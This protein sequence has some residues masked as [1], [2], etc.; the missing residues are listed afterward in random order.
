MR[1][2]NDDGEAKEIK[3]PEE[4]ETAL[5]SARRP[6][7]LVV[8]VAGAMSSE[9]P[10]GMPVECTN[11]NDA[12]VVELVRL[13]GG[14]YKTPT[15]P[16][17]PYIWHDTGEG[18]GWYSYESQHYPCPSC[19]RVRMIDLRQDDSGLGPKE[20]MLTVAMDY[21]PLEGKEEARKTAL[22]VLQRTP[23]PWGWVT[24]WGDYG[25]GKT[26]AL[27]CLVADFVRAGVPSK[28]IVASQMLGELTETFDGNSEESVER[29][30]DKYAGYKVLAIDEVHK[31]PTGDWHQATLHRF[32]DR[33][34]REGVRERN[35]LT[36]LALNPNPEQGRT[37][38][39]AH[40]R[41]L[42]SRMTGG[43]VVEVG[44]EDLRPVEA[45]QMR[46]DLES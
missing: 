40:F 15:N 34:Y 12:Q 29:L 19:Q 18:E 17:Q 33:R 42:Q 13:Q 11:C 25:V 23:D 30:L 37:R 24:F 43:I 2:Y 22:K 32:L 5:K 10:E 3:L 1:A 4:I 31:V 14:P 45:E 8:R 21:A 9:G 20:R 28:Y 44:G 38:A 41:Y 6:E 16:K 36:L 46:E 7:R 39:Q 26:H 27:Q 35:H